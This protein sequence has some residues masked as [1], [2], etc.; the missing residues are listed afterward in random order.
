MQCNRVASFPLG[1]QW[2]CRPRPFQRRIGKPKMEKDLLG[3]AKTAQA[4]S[5]PLVKLLEVVE[6]GVGALGRPL[7]VVVNAHAEG[8]AKLI[9]EGY[10]HRLQLL[11]ARNS[12]ELRDLTSRQPAQLTDGELD[13][14]VLFEESAESELVAAQAMETEQQVK[15][16]ANVITIAAEAADQIGAEVSDDPVDPDWIARFFTQAQDVSKEELQ[17]LWGRLLA[18]EV[19]R[20]G[21]VPLRTLDILRNLTLAEA[22]AFE[23]LAARLTVTGNYLPDGDELLS[24]SEF[25]MLQDANL[26]EDAPRQVVWTVEPKKRENVRPFQE[27][28]GSAL[29]RFPSG[30]VIAV[31]AHRSFYQLNVWRLRMSAYPLANA[32][33]KPTDP[34]YL[35][36]VAEAIDRQPYFAAKLHEPGDAPDPID[37][38]TDAVD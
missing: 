34:T 19:A 24:S 36:Q 5:K 10:D 4:L 29:L 37:A 23:K 14:E 2:R 21:M 6:S 12:N 38:P 9:R 1:Y 3:V 31:L 15:R 22:R 30:H 26:V 16:R 25:R 11:R 28:S 20:P 27:P 33:A 32:M 18:G 17:K 8:R 13:I 7:L 35:R